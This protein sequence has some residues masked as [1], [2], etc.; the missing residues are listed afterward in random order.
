MADYKV[1]EPNNYQQKCMCILV[2]DVSG[3]MRKPVSSDSPERRIDRLQKGIETFYDDVKDQ[4]IIKNMLEIGVITFDQEPKVVRKPHL[5]SK[6][7]LVPQL[8]ER[9]STTETVA[10]LEKAFEVINERKLFYNETG[11]TYYRPWL[12][13]ISDGKPSSSQD[14]IDRMAAKINNAVKKRQVNIIGVS[15]V[16]YKDDENYDAIFEAMDKL[17][18]GHSKMIKDFRLLPFFNWLSNS[19]TSLSRSQDEDGVGIDDWTRNI[20]D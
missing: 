15:I 11:Q 6:D 17:S 20:P 2:L 19:F 5:L 14:E 1:Q 10:A 16:D 8:A 4:D 9:G 12:V 13:L 7:N 18:G 3:S